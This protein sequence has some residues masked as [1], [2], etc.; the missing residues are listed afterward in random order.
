MKNLSL[1]L[2]R[3]A[4]LLILC[5]ALLPGTGC[6]ITG[7]DKARSTV[8]SLRT[9]QMSLID[10]YTAA[11]GK[12]WEA[13]P[14]EERV[15]KDKA[16]YD[17]AIAAEKAGSRR[18]LLR[19]LSSQYS[20]SATILRRRAESGRPF[21]SPKVADEMKKFVAADYDRAMQAGE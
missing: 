21:V 1:P 3:Y 4:L 9:V 18:E 10:D 11:E 17:K 7:K 2:R 16:Q 8:A 6:V 20:R 12:Q 19:S 14:F 13:E 15:K 5:A